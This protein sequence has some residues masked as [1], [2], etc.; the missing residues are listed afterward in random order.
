MQFT[1]LAILAIAAVAQAC[2]P[3]TWGCGNNPAPGPDGALY[4]CNSAGN[5]Q[6]SA[7]C[8]GRTC[9]RL[10]SNGGANCIC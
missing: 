1:T 9:C 3:G 5:W 6:F 4:V 10:Q 2:T 7:Q 8:G